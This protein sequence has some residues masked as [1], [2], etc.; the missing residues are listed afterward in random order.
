MPKYF[1]TPPVLVDNRVEDGAVGGR[2][3]EEP[4]LTW[5]G[6]WQGFISLEWTIEEIEESRADGKERVRVQGE[7]V[8][9]ISSV[10]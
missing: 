8:L 5:C 6:S 7:N 4:I 3:A 10:V 9:A 1:H 2:S